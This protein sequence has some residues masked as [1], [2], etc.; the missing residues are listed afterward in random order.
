M[1]LLMPLTSSV[2]L[3]LVADMVSLTS[4]AWLILFLA[5]RI[6]TMAACVS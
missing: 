6:L 1:F 2:P 4:S 3:F 5:L